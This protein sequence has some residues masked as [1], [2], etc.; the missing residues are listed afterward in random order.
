MMDPSRC[1]NKDCEHIQMASKNNM[2]KVPLK[3]TG[4]ILHMKE[5]ILC[6]IVSKLLIVNSIN[7]S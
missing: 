4:H 7:N 2:T 6:T 3:C 5:Q 1:Q